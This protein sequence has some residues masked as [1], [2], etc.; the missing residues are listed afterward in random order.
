MASSGPHTESNQFF[1]TFSPTP[2]LDGSYTLFGRVVEGMDVVHRLG[3]G[4]AIE[5]MTL[6]T[7]SP[8]NEL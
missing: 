4:S 6:V 3:R 5:E 1:I 7:P 8:S 2:H